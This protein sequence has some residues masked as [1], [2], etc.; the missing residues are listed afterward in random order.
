MLAT[1]A[2]VRRKRDV[3][4]VPRGLCLVHGLL[5]RSSMTERRLYV[6][7]VYSSLV[8][9]G[10]A[11]HLLEPSS[12]SPCPAEPSEVVINSARQLGPCCHELAPATKYAFPLFLAR[13]RAVLMRLYCVHAVH[14]PGLVILQHLRYAG[15]YVC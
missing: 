8:S 10:A 3:P 7:P 6:W 9:R 14:L 15:K 12:V 13:L 1:I 4:G 2:Q 11:N 5:R